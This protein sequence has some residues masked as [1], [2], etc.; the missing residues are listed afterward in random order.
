MR[1]LRQREAELVRH[2]SPMTP[3]ILADMG[4]DP[5]RIPSNPTTLE[6]IIDPFV[7]LMNN[8]G[9]MSGGKTNTPGGSP[10]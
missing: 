4:V 6:Q 10:P 2:W 9:D 3:R 5:E 7:I 8:I 1:A